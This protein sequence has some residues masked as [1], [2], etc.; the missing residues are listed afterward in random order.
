MFIPGGL[1]K[2]YFRVS[3]LRIAVLYRH[4][5]LVFFFACVCVCVC[6]S[7]YLC[8]HA[9]VSVC[10]HNI[11]VCVCMCVRSVCVCVCVRAH[12]HMRSCAGMRDYPLFLN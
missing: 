4:F 3:A 7:V 8:V 6:V 1:F 12:T 10:I 5:F 2:S 11:C 9:C